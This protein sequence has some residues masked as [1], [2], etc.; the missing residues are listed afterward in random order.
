MSSE[1]VAEHSGWPALFWDAFTQ[2]KNAMVLL[3]DARRYVEV[4]GAYL[5]LL[6]YRRED[7]LGNPVYDHVSGGPLLTERQWRATLRRKQFNGVADLIC[8]GGGRVRVEFAGHPEVVTGRQLVLFVALRAAPATRG[9]RNQPER[10]PGSVSLSARELEII[11]LIAMGFSGPEIAGELQVTH[12][13][14]RTHTRNTMTKL[15]ARSR[16]QLVAKSL[17]EGLLW[18]ERS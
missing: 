5:Q 12:N 15:G 18:G 3:D 4:N 1:A 17:G 2:S 14:V 11:R 10:P 16:A 9:L 7:L 13:T 8:S 6:G